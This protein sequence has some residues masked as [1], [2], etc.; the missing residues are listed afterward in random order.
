MSFDRFFRSAQDK[1]AQCKN[2]SVVNV[3]LLYI[4]LLFAAGHNHNSDKWLIRYTALEKR[5]GPSPCVTF[6]GIEMD[7]IA[8]ELRL[9]Q[10]K[11]S[12]LKGLIR[13]W[14]GRRSC[15]KRELQSLVGKLQHACKVVRP[16]RSFLRR[17]FELLAGVHKDHHH[18]RLNTSFRSDLVWWDTFLEAWNGK[19]ILRRPFDDAVEDVSLFSDASG[20]FGC[21]AWWAR[22]WFQFAWPDCWGG[23]N[24]TL[25]EILPV[26]LACAVWG[27]QWR[28]R[29]VV[30]HVDNEGAVAVLNSGSSKKGQIMHLMRSLFFIVAHYQISLRACHVPGAQNGIADAIS[31]DNLSLFFSLLQAADPTPT[32]LPELLVALLVT[33]QPDW[34]STAWPQLFKSCFRRGWQP[35]P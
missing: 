15:V 20:S 3:T 14:L 13:C 11:I 6:L 29:K 24:I 19:S 34:T 26:V 16:G 30:A 17:M 12:E 32:H 8:M 35:L 7:S 28:G 2:C 31:R 1:Y 4:P 33:E 23:R 10:K 18:I 9:P 22:H 21:G 25:K 27:P 5:E